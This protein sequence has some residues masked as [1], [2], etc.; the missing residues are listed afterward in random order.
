M[1][2]K[3]VCNQPDLDKFSEQVME[4]LNIAY[5]QTFDS[6]AMMNY[7][8]LKK[9]KAK[10]LPCFFSVTYQPSLPRIDENLFIDE[11][12]DDYDAEIREFIEQNSI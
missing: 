5:Q 12:D 6:E 1:N 10:R 2:E 8:F 11:S 4:P 7:C 3:I 9:P